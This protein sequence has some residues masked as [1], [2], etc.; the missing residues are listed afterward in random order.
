MTISEYIK[1]QMKD[2]MTVVALADKGGIK[3]TC[4]MVEKEKEKYIKDISK[5]YL[6]EHEFT[7]E[8]SMKRAIADF[9]I[10]GGLYYVYESLLYQQ[11]DSKLIKYN[12]KST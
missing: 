11:I 10:Q 1:K 5:H 9:E 6:E 3:P 2:E 7:V 4:E 12:K 8:E